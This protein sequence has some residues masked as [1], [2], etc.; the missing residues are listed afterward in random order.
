MALPKIFVVALRMLATPVVAPTIRVVAAPA[1]FTVVA[2]VLTKLNVA[3]EVVKSP[4]LTA[5]SPL[6]VKFAAPRSPVVL[7]LPNVAAALTT[8]LPIFKLANPL[9]LI[10]A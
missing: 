8:R 5:R 10:V 6:R 4:P 2:S 1:K 3:A 9:L 7:I